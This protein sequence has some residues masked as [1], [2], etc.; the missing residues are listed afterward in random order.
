MELP[1]LVDC[2]LVFVCGPVSS[3]K[4]WL[5]GKWNM[6]MERSLRF[7]STADCLGPEYAHTWD[8]PALLIDTIQA[9]P[10]YY[11]IAYHPGKN[12]LAG[13]DWCQKTIW[14]AP[15]PRWFILDEVHEYCSTQ[16]MLDGME[17]SIRYSRHVLLGVLCA[18]QRF[19]DVAR[20]L[21]QNCRMIVLFHT[22]EG[23]DLDSIQQRLGRD[24]RKQVENLRPCIYDD[25]NKICEQEPQCLVWIRGQ[26]TRVYELGDKI[27]TGTQIAAPQET[28]W[29]DNLPDEQR[30]P[31]VQSLAVPSGIQES[32]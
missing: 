18:S 6:A 12:R 21:T 14:L 25:A 13:F 28:T 4:T 19:A 30:M 2:T 22:T 26:G 15:L 5:L 29:Q 23:V 16:S 31:E 11:R 3:G 20:L 9:N 1:P 24:V 10:Y 27:K 32:E 17:D 8:N 7:D